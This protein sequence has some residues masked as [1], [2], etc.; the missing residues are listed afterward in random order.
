M[1]GSIFALIL[2]IVNIVLPLSIR[3]RLWPLLAYII[4]MTTVFADWARANETLALVFTGVVILGIMAS[5]IC[6]AVRCLRTY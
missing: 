1:L 6:T 5:W 4:L 3:L 2:T